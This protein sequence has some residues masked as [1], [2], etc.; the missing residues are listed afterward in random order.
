MYILYLLNCIS[1]DADCIAQGYFELHRL[2]YI[3]WFKFSRFRKKRMIL[4]QT[5][6]IG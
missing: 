6:I 3:E 4:L 5:V 1:V 2:K